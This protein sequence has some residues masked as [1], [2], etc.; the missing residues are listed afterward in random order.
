MVTCTPVSSPHWYVHPPGSPRVGKGLSPS[1]WVWGDAQSYPNPGPQERQTAVGCIP[2]LRGSHLHFLLPFRTLKTC[3]PRKQGVGPSAGFQRSLA[4]PAG[5]WL[6][7]T[8]WDG[9]AEPRRCVLQTPPGGLRCA[10]VPG[11]GFH[12]SCHPPL[13]FFIILGFSR[14]LG[15]ARCGQGTR[16]DSPRTS[17]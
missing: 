10:G 14:D 2:S 17:A 11:L 9:P 3:L 13:Q 8:P 15:V 6:T 4:G 16:R 1:L 5:A 12:C 7:V